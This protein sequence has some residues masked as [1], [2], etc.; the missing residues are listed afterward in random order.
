MKTG[1]FDGLTRRAALKGG[2]GALASGLALGIAGPALARQERV[3]VCHWDEGEQGYVL[4]TVAQAGW[5][6]G[7]SDHENDYLAGGIDFATDPD[8][9][10]GCAIVCLSG[11]CEEGF[12]TEV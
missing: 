4:I 1:T 11:V 6:H 8:N 2:I 10:G 5:D 9:C 7:H 12:C 3:D